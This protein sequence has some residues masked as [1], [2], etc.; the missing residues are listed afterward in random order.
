MTSTSDPGRERSYRG[1]RALVM[2]LG[3]HGGGA[4]AARYLAAQG[5]VV[6]VTDLADATALAETVAGLRD[7]G[8]ERF[9]LGEHRDADFR[10]AELVVVNPAV[11]PDNRW[12]ELARQSGAIVTSEIELFLDACPALVV[13]VTG[14]SGKSTTA[15]M[16]AAIL[17]A[18]SRPSD[19]VHTAVRPGLALSGNI[20]RELAARTLARIRPDDRVVLEG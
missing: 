1:R 8:I 9:H 4:A 19:E 5:A 7:A 20:W 12:V 13:G 15:A 17:E 10:K 6:T 3:R 2:G 16:T 11:K 14:S 18:A